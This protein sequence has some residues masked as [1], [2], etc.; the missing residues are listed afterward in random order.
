MKLIV[1]GIVAVFLFVGCNL[2]EAVTGSNS[3]AVR[4]LG[5]SQTTEGEDTS[6]SAAEADSGENAAADSAESDDGAMAA[7]D[8]DSSAEV[9]ESEGATQAADASAGEAYPVDEAYPIVEA[10]EAYPVAGAQDGAAVE[11]YPASS[12]AEQAGDGA[13]TGDGAADT[14]EA[15]DVA[16]GASTDEA[17]STDATEEAASEGEAGDADEAA[18]AETTEEAADAEDA[19]ETEEAA[20]T[21]VADEAV[22]DENVAES[23]EAGAVESGEATAEE[24]S[25]ENA[26]G[27]AGETTVY[28]LQLGDSLWQIAQDNGIEL[29]TLMAVNNITNPNQITAGD[30]LLIPASDDVAAGGV[31]Q[32][33]IVQFGDTLSLIAQ[34]FGVTMEALQ[35]ANGIIN[36]NRI[37]IGQSLIIPAP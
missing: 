27:N 8:D 21:T 26:A 18:S 30:E 6:N 15:G 2:Q 12:D 24:Q 37:E 28:I 4:D 13:T 5:A 25:A 36:P 16:G 34:R 3:N 35:A 14:G 31:E 7:S 22:S 19:A 1:V 20:E 9:V 17:V 10:D 29:A 23:D 33:Y 32:T 11:A